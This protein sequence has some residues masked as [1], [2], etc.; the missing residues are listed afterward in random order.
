MFIACVLDTQLVVNIHGEDIYYFK[1]KYCTT[2]RQIGEVKLVRVQLVLRCVSTREVC[3]QFV[4]LF[5]EG[6]ICQFL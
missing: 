2:S 6:S 3:I 1:L 4:L 5:L